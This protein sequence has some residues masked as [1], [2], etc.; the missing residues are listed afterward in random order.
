MVKVTRHAADRFAERVM[1]LHIKELTEEQFNLVS[2]KLIVLLHE[3]YPNHMDLQSGTFPIKEHE[4]RIV[5]EDQRII[6][7]KTFCTELPPS[8]TGGVLRS[9]K[10][11]R[12]PRRQPKEF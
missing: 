3:A 8:A 7:V 2:E 1:G 9:S 12:K 10:S 11:K 5:K 6:T 4:C